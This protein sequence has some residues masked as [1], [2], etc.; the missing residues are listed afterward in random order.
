MPLHNLPLPQR[1]AA[2]VAAWS[3]FTTNTASGSTIFRPASKA[4]A[5]KLLA[6]T[7][8]DLEELQSMDPP[9]GYGRD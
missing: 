9:R 5:Q 8:L 3:T 4:L 6:I 1:W 2:A 7:E